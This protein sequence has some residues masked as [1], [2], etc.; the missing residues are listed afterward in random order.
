MTRRRIFIDHEPCQN[1]VQFVDI[2]NAI[3]LG[4]VIRQFARLAPGI[5]V[6]QLQQAGLDGSEHAFDVG[7]VHT[8]MRAADR[9]H[10]I[11]AQQCPDGH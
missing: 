1:S 6:K 9:G 4:I 2:Q 10:G 8:H 11:G 7:L 3:Y 5:P